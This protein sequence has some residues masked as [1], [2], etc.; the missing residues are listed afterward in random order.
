MAEVN[1]SQSVVVNNPQGLHARPAD[2]FVSTAC[3]FEATVEVEK[4]GVRVDGKSIMAIL[5][6]AAT[7]GSELTILASGSDAQQALEALVE[8]LQNDCAVS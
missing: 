3:R 8:V 5:T 6:L 1:H 4:D 7:Q 2:L